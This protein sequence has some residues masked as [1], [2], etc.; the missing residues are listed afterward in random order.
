MCVEGEG[1]AASLLVHTQVK[2]TIFKIASRK[3][4]FSRG[5]KKTVSSHHMA[6]NSPGVLFSLRFHPRAVVKTLRVTY[7]AAGPHDALGCAVGLLRR[8]RWAARDLTVGTVSYSF[9][10]HF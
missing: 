1:V 8:P 2:T 10:K 3:I 6:K 5:C 4:A 9:R 7:I